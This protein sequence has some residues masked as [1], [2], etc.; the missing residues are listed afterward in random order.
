MHGVIYGTVE[1][2]RI[3]KTDALST[4]LKMISAVDVLVLF[5]IMLLIA[6]AQPESF[7]HIDRHI[8]LRVVWDEQLLRYLF[9]VMAFGLFVGGVGLMV[10]SRR[11]KRRDDRVRINVLVVSVTSFLGIMFYF[12]Y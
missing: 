3:A 4:L 9:F 10:N 11:L 7:A 5:A 12:L 1:D 8:G 6:Y 2:R